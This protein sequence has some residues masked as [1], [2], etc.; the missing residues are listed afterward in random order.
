MRPGEK[1]PAEAGLVQTV[2]ISSALGLV[3]PAWPERL[4]LP[5][6]PQAPLARRR[7]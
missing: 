6:Q 5:V 2:P 4:A 3:Q 1:K 7:C